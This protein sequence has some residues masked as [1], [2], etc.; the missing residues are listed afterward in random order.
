[1]RLVALQHDQQS[2]DHMSFDNV[3][4]PIVMQYIGNHR[5]Q[6]QFK[7]YIVNQLFPK[8]KKWIL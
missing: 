8:K 7:D 6:L 3:I 1:M 4:E 2:L 5:L